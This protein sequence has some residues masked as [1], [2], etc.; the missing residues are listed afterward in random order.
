MKIF[1]STAHIFRSFT[2]P[3]PLRDWYAVLIGTMFITLALIGGAVNFF[4]AIRSGNITAPAAAELKPTPNV[5]RQALES[6][7]SLYETRLLNYESGN[8]RTPKTS[9][10]SR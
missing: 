3:H 7:V 4:L 5:S 1:Q 8:V 2:K 6:V 9:D 10:P